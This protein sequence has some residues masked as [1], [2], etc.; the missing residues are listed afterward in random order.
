MLCVYMHVCMCIHIKLSHETSEVEKP[1]DMQSASWRPPRENGV[2]FQPESESEGRRTVSNLED[3][4]AEEGLLS[5][6]VFLKLT[7]IG[8]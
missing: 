1:Q 2:Q 3:G 5:I 8:A 4:K 7:F 6:F